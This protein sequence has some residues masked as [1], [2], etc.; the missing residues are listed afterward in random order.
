MNKKWEGYKVSEDK[1]NEVVKKHSISPL[2]A[3]ILLN[4]DIDEAN[5]QKFLH[6]CLDDLYDPFLFNG[7]D[8]VVDRI[9]KAIETKERITVYGDYDV[10]GITSTTILYKFLH[11]LGAEVDYYLPNRLTEGYGLNNE[12]ID[13]IKNRGTKLLVTVD[14]GISAYDEV[15]YAKS[16]G[17]DVIVTDHHECPEKIP[18]CIAVIDAKRADSSYPFN[19]LAG[20][21]VSFKVVQAICQRL[22]KDKSEYLEFLDIVALGTIADIVPLIDENRVIVKF[23]LEKMKKTENLGLRALINLSGIKSIESSSVSFGLAPRINACGRMGNAEL[24]LKM[25]LTDSMKEA[26]EIAEQLN[27]MNRERQ[28]IER[29]IY[30]EVEEQI[31]KENLKNDKVIVAGK[32]NWHHGVIGIVS[33]KITESHYKPSILVSFEGEECK[34]SGR[35]VDGFDLHAALNACS[36]YLLKYGG[37]EMAIGLT[38]KR[39]EF[40]N[41]RKAICEY[42]KDKLPDEAIPTIKYDA[43]ITHKDVSKETIKELNLLEPY[44]EGNPAPLFA[45]KNVKVDSIRTLSNDKHLKLNVKEEHRIFSAI[46]FNMGILKNSIHMGDRADILCAIE[47]NSY[48]GLEMVQL[49]IKDIKKSI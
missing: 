34:G 20:C 12:A 48:N 41:F 32:E 40:D 47:L 39:E 42:A 46:A 26:M 27:S 3:K 18:E 43:E 36:K 2:L 7:M 14:C 45:Y 31:N 38:L 44:G 6:P 23:G 5:I 8:L 22:E 19:S 10:D 21:G 13:E 25:L 1:V 33:S 37:H 29:S 16:L 17:I 49:N 11:S 24:A 35:S 4:R 9:L 30:D 28:E 15:E